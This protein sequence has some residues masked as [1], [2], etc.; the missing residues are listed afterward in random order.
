MEEAYDKSFDV[1]DAD[2]SGY[3]D[4]VE[5]E[6]AVVLLYCEVSESDTKTLMLTPN[7][8]VIIYQVNKYV[9]I[10]RPTKKRIMEYFKVLAIVCV[11][12][13]P[14]LLYKINC[15]LFHVYWF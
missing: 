5:L 3:I 9:R 2:K 1:V 6:L 13:S 7:M 14:L 15:I 11:D 4:E 12:N 8:F 10:K